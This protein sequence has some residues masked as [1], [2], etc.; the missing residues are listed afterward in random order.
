MI[1][2]HSDLTFKHN[3]KQGRHGWL[4]LTPAYS[5]KVVQ[6][7]LRRS[8]QARRVLDPFSGTG[9]TGLVCAERGL[10]C[11]LIEINPFLTWFATAKTRNYTAADIT[12]TRQLAKKAI[13]QAKSLDKGKTLWTPSIHHIERWWSPTRLAALSQVFHAIQSFSS[14]EPAAAVDLLKIAFCRLLIDWSNA[15]F[16]HQ[17]MS[18]K[19]ASP[20]LFDAGERSL[21]FEDFVEQ[22]QAITKAAE[23]TLAGTVNV[24]CGDS[25]EVNL[26]THSQYDA[27]VTSPPYPNRMSYI[28]ELRPYMY[29]LGYLEDGRGAGELD[30][31][32]IGGTWG[33][34]TSRLQQWQPNGTVIEYENFNEMIEGIAGSSPLLARYVHKYFID[35]VCHLQSL[36]PALAPGAQVHY[37]VGNSKFYD[38]L[39]SVEHI[40]ASL[41]RQSGFSNIR[42]ETIRKRN[43]KKELMEFCVEATLR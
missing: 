9:T 28:R 8:S 36:K 3:L 32:A 23:G 30:W 43:S 27:V 41:L 38:T 5:V 31:Q 4:R 6:E 42:I 29:W 33:I 25:R 13:A 35:I 1:A 40:Y 19:E 11:D 21:I 37:I 18:F 26:L 10:H 12:A 2:Q 39:V 17:S 20:T 7:I 22:V 16:N 24:Y 14:K 34:A 15:A